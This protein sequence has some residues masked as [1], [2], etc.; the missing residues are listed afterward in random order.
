MEMKN[1]LIV[2]DEDLLCYSLSAALRRNNIRVKTASCAQDA[3]AEINRTF[4]NLCFLDIRLPDA[5]GLALM[6]IV[7]KTSPETKIIIMTANEIEEDMIKDIEQNS[8]YFLPKPF[9]L[10]DVRLLVNRA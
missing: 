1:I 9:E 6:K 7:R 5:D 2:D 4:Y 8:W 10:K 3:L